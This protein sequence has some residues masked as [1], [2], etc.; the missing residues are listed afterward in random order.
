MFPHQFDYGHFNISWLKDVDSP[1]ILAK[2]EEN[3]H[4]IEAIEMSLKN[5]YDPKLAKT[6]FKYFLRAK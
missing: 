1:Y 3:E 5:D 2:L 6:Y 4:I